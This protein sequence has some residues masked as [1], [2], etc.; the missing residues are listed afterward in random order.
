[1]KSFPACPL[2]HLWT[3]GSLSLSLLTTH[4]E[5]SLPYRQAKDVVY[6]EIHGTGLLMDV[7]TPISRTNGV[8][9]VDVVSGAWYSDR[10]KI[11]DHTVAQIYTILCGRGYT[12]Y[13][14]R[15]GSKSR[16]TLAEMDQNLKTGIRFIKQH[17]TD[18]GIDPARLGMTGASAGGH[19]ATLAALTPE[20]GKPGAKDVAQRL[21]TRVKAISVFFPPTD[22]VEW[23]TG[24]PADPKMVLPL[25]FLGGGAGHSE[26]E[27]AAMAR[28]VSPLH[29]VGTKP[30]LPF[31]LFHGDADPLV[32]LSHSR[33]L[34]AAINQAGGSAELVIK[35]G[36]GHPWLTL[37]VEIG[38][39]ADWFDKQL[40]RP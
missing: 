28:A 10:N 40:L 24:K 8:A 35:P 14:V 21:D 29:R 30:E 16:Y 4:A 23:D 13:A 17:A 25:L 36:G 12:V 19:L 3:A 9:I 11:R 37:P 7:F 18:Q 26:D 32:P 33:K 27:M 6:G 1:V 2:A 39:M 5:E 31:L 15:P 38:K 22:L 20:S 34:V